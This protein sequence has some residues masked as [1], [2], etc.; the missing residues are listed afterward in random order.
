M[1]VVRGESRALDDPGGRPENGK[2]NTR[3]RV[4][5]IMLAQICRDYSVLPSLD[6]I[7][8]GEICFFY[9]MLRGELIEATKPKEK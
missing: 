9:D 8:S 6:R 7:T 1:P 3:I 4:F 2:A 5:Q